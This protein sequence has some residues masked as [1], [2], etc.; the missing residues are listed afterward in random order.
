MKILRSKRCGSVGREGF[1]N[2]VEDAA[3][4]FKHVGV[5]KHLRSHIDESN[6]YR[7]IVREKMPVEAV[8]LTDTAAH[9]HAVNGMTDFLLG[10]SDK[11]LGTARR[12]T[13]TFGG[14]VG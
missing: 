9:L 7:E 11:K 13:V 8:G 12:T 4:G 14:S 1:G 10:D 3:D 6:V 5:G 2:T